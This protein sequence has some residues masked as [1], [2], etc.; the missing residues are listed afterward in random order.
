MKKNTKEPWVD[1]IKITKF[2]TDIWKYQR[3]II[4]YIM[5]ALWNPM[6]IKSLWIKEDDIIIKP[7]T[8]IEL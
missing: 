7:T 5:P 1:I 8:N 2:S 6:I 3:N 4:I